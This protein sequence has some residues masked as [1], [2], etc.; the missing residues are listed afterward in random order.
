MGS[1]QSSSPMGFRPPLPS[2]LQDSR[3]GKDLVLGLQ[4]QESCEG[5]PGPQM[6]IAFWCA[7]TP[8]TGLPVTAASRPPGEKCITD[9]GQPTAGWHDGTNEPE[10]H[11]KRNHSLNLSCWARGLPCLLRTQC[12]VFSSL[13]YCHNT[14][15]LGLHRACVLQEV[16]LQT[17]KQPKSCC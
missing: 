12:N 15:N 9:A 17:L 4:L 8:V 1:P 3:Q 2:Q 10:T 13:S 11:T 6:D 7:V 5:G 16:G 14:R